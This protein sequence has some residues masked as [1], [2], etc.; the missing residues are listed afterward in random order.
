IPDFHA[1]LEDIVAEG[2][3]VVA[4]FTAT[5]T[6]QG[7]FMGITVDGV[8]YTN[9][10]N[11][12]FRFAGGKIVEEWWQMDMLGVL[13]QWG[14]MPPSR[15]TPE[16][17]TWG[18][19]SEVTGDLGDPVTNT[20][21]VL[22]FAQKFWNEHDVAALDYTHS[23]D[24]IAH[25]PAVPGHPLP[26]HVYKQVGLVY[27]AAFPDFRVTIENIIAEADM[28]GVRWTMNGTHLGELMGI[29]PT[30]RPVT[31]AGITIHRLADGKIV[32]NWWSYDALGMMQQI[33]APP[34]P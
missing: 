7:E 12:M 26:Y 16:N 6:A 23:L 13:E 31:F 9:T 2:D 24:I 30:G 19:P 33:T 34:A 29:P 8:Q 11:I 21:T 17:Y 10:W 4:R 5:G 32:E 20:A 22:Y 27:L 18:A 25:D 3:K 14:A 28:V 15:P 1:T